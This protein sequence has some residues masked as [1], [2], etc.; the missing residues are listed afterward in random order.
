MSNLSGNMVVRS[1]V[2]K[3]LTSLDDV[4]TNST[5]GTAA[6]DGSQIY[7]GLDNQFSGFKKLLG[8]NMFRFFLFFVFFI[9]PSFVSQKTGKMVAFGEIEQSFETNSMVSSH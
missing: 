6:G 7:M 3:K 8:E 2:D 4:H 1:A 9:V 5:S